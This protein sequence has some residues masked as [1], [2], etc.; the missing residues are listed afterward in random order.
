M[1]SDMGV[2]FNVI[3]FTAEVGNIEI[4][5]PVSIINFNLVAP[6]FA[7]ISNCS[8]PRGTALVRPISFPNHFPWVLLVGNKATFVN[9]SFWANYTKVYMF[10]LHW[11][12]K[13]VPCKFL[14]IGYSD[15][16]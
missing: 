9:C 8:Q 6:N 14:S 15:T 2:G 5:A 16:A 4:L 10:L 3:P 13:N 12:N 11:R 7:I 1:E